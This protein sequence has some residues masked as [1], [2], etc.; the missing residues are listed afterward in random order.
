MKKSL[1][2]IIYIILLIIITLICCMF[3]I[4]P[5]VLNFEVTKEYEYI[6]NNRKRIEKIIVRNNAQL[7]MSCY[8]LD[9][10]KGYDILNNIDIKKETEM[11]CSDSNIYLDFYF[12]DGTCKEIHFECENLV[13]DGIKYELKDKVILVNKDDYIPDKITKGMIIVS[14]HDQIDCK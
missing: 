8:K 7:G 12:D 13:Y 3:F 9:V 5:K 11:W 2:V 4:K 14:N 10:E 1:K 6:Q